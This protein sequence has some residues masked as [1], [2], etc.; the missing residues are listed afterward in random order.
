MLKVMF[1]DGFFWSPQ[2]TF[3]N[4][5]RHRTQ[6]PHWTTNRGKAIGLGYPA[7]L[8]IRHPK[9]RGGGVHYFGDIV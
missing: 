3:V 9:F 5:D 4:L 1:K 8:K 7:G 6:N 2:L